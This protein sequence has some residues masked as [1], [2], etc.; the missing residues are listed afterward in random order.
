[1]LS[2]KDLSM[3]FGG[4]VALDNVSLTV[5]EGEIVGLIG[6]NGAGKTTV[7]NLISRLYEPT[8]GAISFRG[9]DLLRLR[10]YQIVERGIVRTF[11]LLGL[12]PY[13]T[14][15]ENLMVGEHRDFSR[16]PL[17]V[18]LGLS[19]AR[20]EERD[21][22]AQALWLLR[23]LKMEALA[24]AFVFAL[25]Y[26]TQKLIEL[27]RALLARP[28]LLLLD[29]PV[30]GMNAAEKAAMREFI[31]RINRDWGIT[32]FL[33]EHDMNFVMGLCDRVIVLNYG[34][35]IAEGRADEIQQN[36]EVIAAYLGEGVSIARA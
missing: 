21:R 32:I 5:N 1:M 29:E 17:E 10:P 33:V 18:A 9:E 35:V 25:P 12:F 7:F 11:Q 34:R 24:E 23:F 13:M 28:R 31:K 36:P 30:A 14:V 8:G 22:R 15:L 6:P 2:V 27:L 20:R 19:Q 16:N 4:L 3:R 26:G